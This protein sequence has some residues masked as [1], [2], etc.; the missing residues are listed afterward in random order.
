[1]L[2]VEILLC[3]RNL[4][5]PLC[6]IGHVLLL[7][8]QRTLHG[9]TC[10]WQAQLAETLHWLLGPCHAS[11]SELAQPFSKTFVLNGDRSACLVLQCPISHLSTTSITHVPTLQHTRN[12]HRV[13]CELTLKT[14]CDTQRILQ[15]NLSQEVSW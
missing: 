5:M 14:D 3:F 15:C 9:V 7:N 4:L 11:D 2:A 1:M 6:C 8:F 10:R 13:Q 12:P